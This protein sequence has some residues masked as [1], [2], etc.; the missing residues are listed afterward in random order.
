MREALAQQLELER[1]RTLEE[2]RQKWETRELRLFT[3]LATV[4]EEL[5]AAR[6]AATDTTRTSGQLS[7]LPSELNAV[8]SLGSS[9]T[10]ENTRLRNEN[11]RLGRESLPVRSQGGGARVKEEHGT[12]VAQATN[13]RPRMDSRNSQLSLRGSLMPACRESGTGSGAFKQRDHQR[14]PTSADCGVVGE[15]EG[16]GPVLVGDGDGG[17]YRSGSGGYEVASVIGAASTISLSGATAQPNTLTTPSAHHPR[18]VT[19]ATSRPSSPPVTGMV[20]RGFHDATLG[21]SQTPSPMPPSYMG[22]SSQPT[23]PTLPTQLPQGIAGVDVHGRGSAI[24]PIWGWNSLSVSGAAVQLQSNITRPQ[25]A[26][27][28]VSCP[29]L[30]LPSSG[31]NRLSAASCPTLSFPYSGY[32]GHNT[33]SG[34]SRLAS[35]MVYHGGDTVLGPQTGVHSMAY[36]VTNI[37]PPDHPLTT[38][39]VADTGPPPTTR[40]GTLRTN[41]GSTTTMSNSADIPTPPIPYC[42]IPM[43]GQIPQVPRFT[44]EGRAT[45]DSFSEWHEHFE[46]VATLACWNDHWKL[47]HLTSNLRDT[48][49]AFYRSC[50]PDV[51]GNYSGLVAAMERR[52]TPIRLTAV[53]AQ[54]FHTRQQQEKESVDQFAQELRKLYNLAYAGAATEGPQAERMGQTLLANQFISGLR[55][56]LKRKLIGTEGNMEE[57]ILKARFEEAKTRELM[58]EKPRSYLPVNLISHR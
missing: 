15:G 32:G 31:D 1:Y 12:H 49:M 44:G 37:S 5:R 8:R 19:F 9:L 6:T 13:G 48:A 18:T 43:M 41:C 24:P 53:Q 30:S 54:L 21:G 38:A 45:G 29:P 17:C 23:Q 2:Q 11:E 51:R 27:H 20:S 7:T 22:P 55:A 40:M 47:V 10:E 16:Q 4:E 50:S 52:F 28:L 57:L 3:R 33:L 14:E 56:E 36:G 26:T 35:P 39:M 34:T 58:G 42:P 46:N 25:V